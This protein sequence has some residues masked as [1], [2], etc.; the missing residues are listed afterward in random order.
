[1]SKC[2][3]VKPKKF[4]IVVLEK[5]VVAGEAKTGYENKMMQWRQETGKIRTL[6]GRIGANS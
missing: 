5:V 1:M 3:M 4:F 2:I 6:E